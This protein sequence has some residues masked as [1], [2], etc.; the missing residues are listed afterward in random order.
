MDIR[1]FVLS[2]YNNAVEGVHIQR[3]SDSEAASKPHTH[4]YFQIYYVGKGSITHYV[5]N[6][7]S[8][9]T[10]GDMFII[11]PG[12][13]HYICAA[14]DT[15]FYTFSFMQDTFGEPDGA[16]RL[17]MGFLR[18]LESADGEGIRPKITLPSDELLH[19][20]SIMEQMLKVF[21][22][23]TLGYTEVMRAYGIILLTLF[24]RL[25]YEAM[26]E[27]F[28]LDAENSRQAVLFGIAYIES[29]YAEPLSLDSIAKRCAMSRSSFCSIF[30]DITGMTFLH[31]LNT[32]RINHAI[33]L[34]QKG[35]KITSIYELCGY[36][37]F[38]TFYRNFKKVTGLSPEQYR[39]AERDG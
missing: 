23:K 2:Y 31:Y 37:D 27:K 6:V 17:A 12:T 28:P 3:I 16:N 22:G 24:A 18:F 35:Y 21:S 14:A 7:S 19:I 9:L 32:C 15:V 39:K 20:E 25:Y 5:G 34:I 38:S 10:R 36:R 11:P 1:N 13:T 26:P 33:R 8:K 30:S 4:A 29:N